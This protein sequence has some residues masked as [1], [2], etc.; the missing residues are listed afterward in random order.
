MISF[1]SEDID[2]LI[3]NYDDLSKGV[4][5]NYELENAEQESFV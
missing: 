4:I 5:M 1:L 3:E 2:D